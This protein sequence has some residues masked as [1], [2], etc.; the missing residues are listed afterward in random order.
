[1][2]SYVMRLSHEQKDLS[3]DSNYSHEY[4][5]LICT[6]LTVITISR[7]YFLISHS[8]SLEP[9]L[10]PLHFLHASDS[11]RQAL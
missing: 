3:T 11:T 6:A 4:E 1:M 7:F 2:T 8:K 5:K 10:P 9:Y